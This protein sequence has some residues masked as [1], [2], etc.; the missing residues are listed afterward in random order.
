MRLLFTFTL[1]CLACVV[2]A[3]TLSDTSQTT[4]NPY[5]QVQT[6]PQFM[7]V[8][9][10]SPTLYQ[11]WETQLAFFREKYKGQN[12][13]LLISTKVSQQKTEFLKALKAEQKQGKDLFTAYADAL[14]TITI[15]YELL[16]FRHQLYLKQ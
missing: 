8:S 2:Q 15:K 16:D 12:I 7:S 4:K 9:V 6:S 10:V 3:Q 14:K 11:N 13:L 1:L 5:F